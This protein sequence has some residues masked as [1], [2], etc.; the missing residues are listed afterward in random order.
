MVV[1]IVA[2]FPGFHNGCAEIIKLCL[3]HG[4]KQIF[5]SETIIFIQ[6]GGQYVKQGIEKQQ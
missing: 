1:H 6:A 2:C 5:L 3:L 4:E